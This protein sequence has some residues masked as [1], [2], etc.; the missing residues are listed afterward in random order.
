MRRRAWLLALV[1]LLG[2]ALLAWTL[3]KP[4]SPLAYMVAGT[5]A[6]TICLLGVFVRLITHREFN[7]PLRK[8][9]PAEYLPAVA[10][11]EHA[12]PRM[13]RTSGG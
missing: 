8:S 10:S 3:S 7:R 2:I 5:L 1:A 12:F 11:R 13:R 6:T 9:Y 4:H